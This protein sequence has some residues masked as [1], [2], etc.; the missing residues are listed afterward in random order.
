MSVAQALIGYSGFVGG[1]L[2]RQA[3]FGERYNSKNIEEI[4]GRRFDLVV[5]AGAP[6]AKW[7]ANRNPAEDRACLNRLS[8]A[9]GQVEAR[10]FV[11]ISTVD[12]YPDPVD[13][14]EDSEID[15]S[16][17][18][19]YGK[20]RR[21]L[22]R[23]VAE[24]FPKALIVRL[25]GLYGRGLKKN[26]IYD[27]LNDNRL[28]LVP[29]DGVFQ[30]YNLHRL[31]SDIE[32]AEGGGLRLANFATEPVSVR[33]VAWHAF[34]RRFENQPSSPAPRYDLRTRHAGLWGRTGPYLAS[35]EQVLDEIRSF[36][37]STREGI[38]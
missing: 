24:R 29:A 19:P 7:I 37:R 12:V 26:A 11:L 31:W 3:S 21:E 32:V 30:F 13:V 16:S 2:D 28:D 22:E 25:P 6:A 36:V 1:N 33:D 15:E 5:C 27:F 18:Q 38:R 14:N 35:R 9:L 23:F 17:L 34:A 4:A 8:A 20:H 10:R